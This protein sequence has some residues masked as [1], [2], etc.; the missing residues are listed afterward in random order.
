MSKLGML[1]AI[2]T[3]D[4]D[5]VIFGATTILRLYVVLFAIYS[6]CILTGLASDLN[7]VKTGQVTKYEADDITDLGFNTSGLILIALLVGGDY[8]VHVSVVND[9]LNM[10][11]PKCRLA[12]R[13]AEF[14]L[15]LGL[16]VLGLAPSSLS[17]S[18]IAPALV[19]GGAA[20][21]MSCVKV[22]LSFSGTSQTPFLLIFPMSK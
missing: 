4:S 20:F 21:V 7:F 17:L 22:P 19:L 3:Q 1:D 12:L 18:N 2:I 16:P 13:A 5:A 9:A 8:L 11:T 15:L 10:L 6:F 14:K